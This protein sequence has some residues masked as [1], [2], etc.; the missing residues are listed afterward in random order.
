ML[1]LLQLIGSYLAL[2]SIVQLIAALNTFSV[3]SLSAPLLATH[4]LLAIAGVGFLMARKWSLLLYIAGFITNWFTFFII[5]QEQNHVVSFWLNTP[6]P[7][8]TFALIVFN[9]QKFK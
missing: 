9:W 4:L 5:S 1:L 8:I 7:A 6:L 2:N 3:L